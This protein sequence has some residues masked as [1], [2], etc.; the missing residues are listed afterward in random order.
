[1]GK[2]AMCIQM[3]Q[4][5]N[6]GRVYK[7]SELADLL[8]TNPRNI[9]EYKKELEEAGYYIISIPG[10][11]GGYQLDK[12]AIM[13]SLKFT[14]EE[15]KAV[16]DGAGY[17][18]AR[19]DFLLKKDF[20]TA[21]SKIYSSMRHSEPQVE[22][23]VLDRFPLSMQNKEIV[24]RYNA[25]EKCI[26]R[27]FK[28]KLQYLSLKNEMTDRIFHP[29]R[30]FMYNNAWYVI[31]FDEKSGEIRYFKLN[32]INSFEIRSEQKFRRLLTYNESDYFDEYGMKQNGEWYPI[33]LQLFDQYAMLVKERVYGKNQ[34]VEA[35]EDGSSILTCEMQNKENIKVF[36]LGFGEH[37]KVL[38]PEWLREEIKKTI[39][40]LKGMYI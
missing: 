11:F 26:L 4:I 35:L 10:K 12:T 37:C 39:R 2:S 13:P 14:E 40:T 34:T 3:L 18:E 19:N 32:R 22:P 1:M 33:K 9:I 27:Q 24:D 23:L 36:V 30:L 6:S 38:E 31:G 21:M 5:L 17:L 15:K 28:I 8:E 25:L 29:Y 16:S 20:Q 7:A